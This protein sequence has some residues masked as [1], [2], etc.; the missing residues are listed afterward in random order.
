MHRKL[1][2]D[3]QAATANTNLPVEFLI[4]LAQE[5]TDACQAANDRLEKVRRLLE[6]GYRDEA[7]QIA[8]QTPVL[9]ELIAQLDFTE[10]PVWNGL[11]SQHSI[12]PAPALM[13]D[14]ASKIDRAYDDLK[15]LAP[16]L[17]R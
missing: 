5:Y 13:I 14:V 12:E 3:I 2:R 7:I 6:E 8:E 15:R 17:K 4:D 1:I 10:L 9:I 16:L 11:L